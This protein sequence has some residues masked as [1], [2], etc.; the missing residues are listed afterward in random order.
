MD[1]AVPG[2]M[3]TVGNQDGSVDACRSSIEGSL[4]R[5][6]TDHVDLYYQHRMDP[7]VPIE[8]TVGAMADLV[9]EGKIRHI[10]LSEA[11]PETIRRANA[12]HP[13]T[14]VQCEYRC[15]RGTRRM[16]CCPPVGSS[17]SG[18]WRTRRWGAVFSRGVCS[19]ES[20]TRTI[21][22]GPARGSP[23]RI[24]TPTSA[25]P[26]RSR[27]S[28]PRR[29]SRRPSSRSHGCSRER[30]PRSDPWDEAP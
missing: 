5:M 1:E 14:A 8:E 6:E 19:P 11:A 3:S 10:G 4:A 20:S 24:S 12:V 15:G 17:G 28:L 26:T 21:S 7:A 25:S 22:A 9:M 16:R 27:R 13:I 23:A 30:R 2:D 18:S 29:R